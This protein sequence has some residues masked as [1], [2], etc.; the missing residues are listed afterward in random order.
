[1]GVAGSKVI[2]INN[3]PIGARVIEYRV[4]R[5]PMESEDSSS[6]MFNLGALLN[7]SND[8]ITC[9][10]GGGV[11]VDTC[12]ITQSTSNHSLFL[13]PYL[14]VVCDQEAEVLSCAGV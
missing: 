4:C 9:V 7:A 13:H 5:A 8:C 12:S 10:C 3:E 1:M 14:Q 6:D 2:C 11:G